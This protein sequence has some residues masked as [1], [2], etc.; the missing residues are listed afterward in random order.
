MSEIISMRA[1]AE[2]VGL[3]Y[4][5]FRKVWPAWCADMAF[6]APVHGC[7]WDVEAIDAWI[8]MRTRRTLTPFVP[9]PADRAPRGRAQRSRDQLAALRS[10]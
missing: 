6:P 2:R 4:E 8:V 1:T 5:R 9:A 10:A 3:G 7:H